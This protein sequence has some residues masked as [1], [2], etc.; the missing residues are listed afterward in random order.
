MQSSKH[1]HDILCN[2]VNLVTTYHM[3]CRHFLHLDIKCTHSYPH[4]HTHTHM[5]TRTHAYTHMHTHIHIQTHIH[6]HLHPH[7]HTCTPTQSAVA[8]CVVV[9]VGALE[10]CCPRTAVGV[11]VFAMKHSNR[12]MWTST[13]TVHMQLTHCA[14]THTQHRYTSLARLTYD[15]HHGM[16]FACASTRRL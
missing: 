16:K 5:H 3:Y 2:P 1:G 11:S 9:V 7:P 14:H 10:K 8:G 4:M 6:T 12:D 13:H 15:Y